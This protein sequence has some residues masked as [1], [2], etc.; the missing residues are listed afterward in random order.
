MYYLAREDVQEG[1]CRR[2]Y[3]GE[4]MQDAG[5]DMQER[6]S[7]QDATILPEEPFAKLSGKKI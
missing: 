4:N 5:G 2:G 7:T 1:I 6:T 3:A